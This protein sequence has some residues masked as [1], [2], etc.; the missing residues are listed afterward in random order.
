[1]RNFNSWRTLI[2][3]MYLI[4]LIIASFDY[5]KILNQRTFGFNYSNN[6]KKFLGFMKELVKKEEEGYLGGLF[7]IFEK[8][9]E[10]WLYIRTKCF[11][12]DIHGYILK[13][14]V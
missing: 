12:F 3:G 4:F 9:W 11:I 13:P 1:M 7:D 10:L 8:T 14:I 5:L 6:L 2:L